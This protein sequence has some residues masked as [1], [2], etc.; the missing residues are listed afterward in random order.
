MLRRRTRVSSFQTRMPQER[1]MS[2]NNKMA[3]AQPGQRAKEEPLNVSTLQGATELKQNFYACSDDCLCPCLLRVFNFFCTQTP[4]NH[5]RYDHPSSFFIG[6]LSF[7]TASVEQEKNAWTI[8][9]RILT[10]RPVSFSILS[11]KCILSKFNAYIIVT[12]L[13]SP[14]TSRV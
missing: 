3:S 13:I 12:K 1:H 10:Y 2:N 11:F 14:I 4:L 8:L 6:F 9:P 7:F 5:F